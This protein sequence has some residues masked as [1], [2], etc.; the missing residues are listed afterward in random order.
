[1]QFIQLDSFRRFLKDFQLQPVEIFGTFT[2][3]FQHTLSGFPP[4]KG[5]G[6]Y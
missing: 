5:A 3:A 6:D 2:G 4:L 1:M